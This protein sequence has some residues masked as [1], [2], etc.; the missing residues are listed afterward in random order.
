MSRRNPLFFS[1]VALAFWVLSVIQVEKFVAQQAGIVVGTEFGEPI[2]G[3]TAR[4]LNCSGWG[5]RTSTKWK[6]P[7]KDGAGL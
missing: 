1:F 6:R 4:N 7:T 3:I 5:W 2:Q